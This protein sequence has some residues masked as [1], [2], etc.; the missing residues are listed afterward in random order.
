MESDN[1]MNNNDIEVL[2][3]KGFEKSNSN[4]GNKEKDSHEEDIF[5]NDDQR[6]MLKEKI[7]DLRH[8][9]DL[10]KSFSDKVYCFLVVWCISLLVLIISDASRNDFHIPEIV[11]TTL[12]GGTTVSTLG[13][14]GFIVQGLFNQVV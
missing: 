11:L 14:V 8:Y 10:R 3:K 12:C 5:L 2:I 1:M 4:I 7:E 9:R 6:I 13:L